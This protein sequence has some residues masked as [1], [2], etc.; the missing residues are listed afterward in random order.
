MIDPEFWLDEEISSLTPMARLL[1]I[2]LWG[3][4][5]DNYATLPNKPAWITAQVFPYED[6][7]NTLGLLDELQKVR[8]IVAFLGPDDKEYWYIKNFF[9]YQRVD[10]PSKPKYPQFIKEDEI[11]IKTL[12]EGSTR[13][14]SEVKLS[15]DKLN[16][17]T[18]VLQGELSKTFLVGDQW[19]R[20]IDAFEPL[21]PMFEDFYKNKTERKAL[22]DVARKI[23]FEKTLATIYELPRITA[24]P[25]APKITKPTELKRDLGKLITFHKQLNNTSKSNEVLI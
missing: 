20:L 6:S 21:N 14:R 16:S 25:Y 23:T 7:P 5:D 15:K 24:L 18:G 17:K 8:K 3:I 1:Y 4:C 2:G 19:N 22:D 9:K 11:K 12:D 10:R 13:A